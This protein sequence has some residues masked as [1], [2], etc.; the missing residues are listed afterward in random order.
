MGQSGWG[1]AGSFTQ[2]HI[3]SQME[4]VLPQ[5]QLLT[6]RLTAAWR[7]YC[8]F[9][10]NVLEKN[11]DDHS[12]CLCK[13][14]FQSH[15]HISYWFGC[16]T[17]RQSADCPTPYSW[18]SLKND[19]ERHFSHCLSHVLLPFLNQIGRPERNIAQSMN[20]ANPQALLC[21]HI[22]ALE[23]SAC[24]CLA[25]L[26]VLMCLGVIFPL[27]S[28]SD[29]LGVRVALVL[30][31]LETEEV[32]TFESGD[33]VFSLPW[34]LPFAVWWVSLQAQCPWEWMSPDLPFSALILV[35]WLW[36]VAEICG[37]DTAAR[38]YLPYLLSD[39]GDLGFLTLYIF[40]SFIQNKTIFSTLKKKK[41]AKH[42]V[43]F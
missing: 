1:R 35:S 10:H 3:H 42:F 17:K 39:C 23:W 13:A 29:P 37:R 30:G 32:T 22:Q 4:S 9:L 20:C 24:L 2:R 43:P 16:L 11:V 19:C 15:L 26:P 27:S 5:G 40:F 33:D 18:F 8:P 34:L 6:S 7:S 36:P 31:C 41:K 28:I 12:L 14:K 38:R 25:P 21:L